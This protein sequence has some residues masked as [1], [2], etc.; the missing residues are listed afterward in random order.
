[1]I[2]ITKGKV[3]NGIAMDGVVVGRRKD[4]FRCVLWSDNSFEWFSSAD[5]FNL[6]GA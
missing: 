3:R 4:D 5:L 2:H 1:M 6:F